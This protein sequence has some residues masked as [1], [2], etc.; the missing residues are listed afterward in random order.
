MIR[1]V[2]ILLFY[3]LLLIP[4]ILS[5]AQIVEL[6]WAPFADPISIPFGYAIWMFAAYGGLVVMSIALL[7]RAQLASQNRKLRKRAAAMEAEL[8]Q[9]RTLITME[10]ESQ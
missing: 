4:A 5:G 6:Q 2:V 3:A 9:L 7:D 10:N 8:T 1:F